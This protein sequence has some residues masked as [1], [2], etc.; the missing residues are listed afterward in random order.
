MVSKTNKMSV[1]Y[2]SKTPEWETPQAFFE[3]LRKEFDLTIDV[4]ANAKNKKLPKYFSET[5]D[6]LKQ[7]WRGIRGWMNPPYGTE[8]SQWIEKA[9]LGGGRS[10]CSVAPNSHRH[11]VVSRFYI[12]EAGGTLRQ[13]SLEVRQL[14]ECGAFS[15][16][17]GDIS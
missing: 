8:I 3:V 14:Q 15:Q 12:Q 13:R 5:Q 11:A 16:Y 10:D 6:G 2:S 17:G 1:H 9:S 7:S 4:C